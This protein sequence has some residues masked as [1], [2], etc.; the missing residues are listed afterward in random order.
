MELLNKGGSMLYTVRDSDKKRANLK[1]EFFQQ[2][3]NA[4]TWDWIRTHWTWGPLNRILRIMTNSVV[5]AV[6]VEDLAKDPGA[7]SC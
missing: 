3:R 7:Q 4:E 5:I 1:R 6:Q 2:N